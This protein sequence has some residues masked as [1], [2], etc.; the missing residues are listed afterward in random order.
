M[1]IILNNLPTKLPANVTDINELVVWKGIKTQGT[2]IAVNDKLIKKI[3][4]KNTLIHPL[5]RVTI[6]S[7]AFGG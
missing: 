5:D 1:D 4:W 3:D 6:I 7:I 2:A